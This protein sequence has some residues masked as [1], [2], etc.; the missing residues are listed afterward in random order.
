MN[1]VCTKVPYVSKREALTS[2]PNEHGGVYR[3][4][5]CPGR[6]YHRGHTLPKKCKR[7][8]VIKRNAALGRKLARREMADAR[9]LLRQQQRRRSGTVVMLHLVEHICGCAARAPE[10]RR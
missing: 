1:T 7:A 9:Q 2:S 10:V 8:A 5:I 4:K 3:C 6:P